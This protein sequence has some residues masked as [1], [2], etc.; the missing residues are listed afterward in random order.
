MIKKPNIKFS[1]TRVR[2]ALKAKLHYNGNKL[3]FAG[4]TKFFMIQ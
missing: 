4:C 2:A 3:I 1:G